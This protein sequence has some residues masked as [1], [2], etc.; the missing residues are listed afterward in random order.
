[1]LNSKPLEIG[2]GGGR[3]E[4]E[5]YS[6]NGVEVD[7]GITRDGKNRTLGASTHHEG[8]HETGPPAVFHCG[9]RLE[10]ALAARG[11]DPRRRRKTAP[12]RGAARL[13]KREGGRK[14]EGEECRGAG[15]RHDIGVT[16]PPTACA[17][18]CL[19]PSAPPHSTPRGNGRGKL[20][21]RERGQGE[22][23]PLHPHTHTVARGVR[24]R[25]AE[26][27]G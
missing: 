16:A 18:A 19:K 12:R 3:Q 2:T 9:G 27:L 24:G 20:G 5:V 6:P 7:V 21:E 10:A 13:R 15:R 11:R 25:A 23:H 14:G 26:G 22:R 4:N 1:M 17:A 8:T